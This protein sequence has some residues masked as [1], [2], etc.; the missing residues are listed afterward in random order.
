MTYDGNEIGK[1]P[2]KSKNI[3]TVSVYN[4]DHPTDR[5]TD[6]TTKAASNRKRNINSLYT[7][8]SNGDQI[9]T[10]NSNGNKDHKNHWQG[11]G[12][13]TKKPKKAPTLLEYTRVAKSFYGKRNV[14]SVQKRVDDISSSKRTFPTDGNKKKVVGKS[15]RALHSDPRA[16]MSES[17]AIYQTKRM[18]FKG[19]KLRILD[20]NK[21]TQGDRSFALNSNMDICDSGRNILPPN[22]NVTLAKPAKITKHSSLKINLSNIHNASISTNESLNG[23]ASQKDNVVAKKLERVRQ[24]TNQSTTSN[25]ILSKDDKATATKAQL[26]STQKERN[27]SNISKESNISKDFLDKL[28]GVYNRKCNGARKNNLHESNVQMQL[29]NSTKSTRTSSIEN[30]LSNSSNLSSKLDQIDESRSAT[31]YVNGEENLKHSAKFSEQL[32]PHQITIQLIGN[33]SRATNETQNEEKLETNNL[34]SHQQFQF[35]KETSRSSTISNEYKTNDMSNNSDDMQYS[36]SNQKGVSDLQDDKTKQPKSNSNESL[37]LESNSDSNPRSDDDTFVHESISVSDS[38]SSSDV[39]K[40][41]DIES[42]SSSSELDFSFVSGA[43]NKESLSKSDHV[44]TSVEK[45][46]M[47]AKTV[48]MK[49]ASNSIFGIK[50]PS[51]NNFSNQ[52]GSKV[53]TVTRQRKIAGKKSSGYIN[54]TVSTERPIVQEE[55]NYIDINDENVNNVNNNVLRASIPPN[56]N[57]S[58]TERSNLPIEILDQPRVKR[59]NISGDERNWLELKLNANAKEYLK[60]ANLFSVDKLLSISAVKLSKMYEVWRGEQKFKPIPSILSLV[61]K[62]QALAYLYKSENIDGCSSSDIETRKPRYQKPLEEIKHLTTIAM[63]KDLPRKY[64]TVI[65]DNGKF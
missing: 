1:I 15:A 34:K 38:N 20:S 44:V 28:S 36:C 35:T 7:P 33:S 13:Y 26:T 21:N 25:N 3:D 48:T 32:T 54:P 19:N 5:H 51:E 57:F 4:T 64:I 31:C 49:R 22:L 47:R 9:P 52:S 65:N 8:A 6:T 10:I 42:H 53:T 46:V 60:S 29:Q 27:S 11:K 18:G 62:W 55:I 30:T 59:V 43:E 63:V 61:A 2:R 50:R 56:D 12:C 16:K 45:N 40:L 17:E 58:Q 41:Q 14:K 23:S 24:S 39:D 37:V